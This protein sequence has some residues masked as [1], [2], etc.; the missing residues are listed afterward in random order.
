[1]A[2]FGGTLFLK[3]RRDYSAGIS[4]IS[5]Q[6]PAAVPFIGM[7][8][9]TDIAHARMITDSAKTDAYAHGLI[10]SMNVSA[11]SNCGIFENTVAIVLLAKC[12]SIVSF[13]EPVL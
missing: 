10:M 4:G 3:I 8:L 9:K 5:S 12:M 2:G 13:N 1:M 11:S 7:F 6:L